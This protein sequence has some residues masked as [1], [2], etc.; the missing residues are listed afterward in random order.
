MQRIQSH[1]RESELE[2]ATLG[3]DSR[4]PVSTALLAL[5]NHAVEMDTGYHLYEM[6]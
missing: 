3:F 6:T 2:S 5:L 1:F 4:G